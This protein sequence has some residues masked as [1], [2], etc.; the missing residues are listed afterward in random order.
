M[1]LAQCTSLARFRISTGTTA[2][3]VCAVKAEDLTLLVAVV[4][5]ETLVGSK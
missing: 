3:N 2:A 5:P 1:H 4:V